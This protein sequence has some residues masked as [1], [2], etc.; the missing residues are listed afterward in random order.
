MANNKCPPP[1][2]STQLMRKWPRRSKKKFLIHLHPGND[3]DGRT[4]A[5][6]VVEVGSWNP[7]IYTV[8]ST[9]QTVVGNGI[10]EASVQY[11]TQT[12]IYIYSP[13][14]ETIIFRAT[15]SVWGKIPSW[16]GTNI[17]PPFTRQNGQTWLS[18]RWELTWCPGHP[19]VDWTA[20][21]GDLWIYIIYICVYIY[22]YV[23]SIYQIMMYLYNQSVVYKGSV[24][25][26]GVS[27]RF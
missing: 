20:W 11:F 5:N 18:S 1:P 2:Q 8:C 4:P 16:E 23:W 26:L 15:I 10:S 3:T 6:S 7:M 22:K 12:Y 25:H 21:Q 17:S 24:K 14:L 9:I 19:W 13:L 27:I